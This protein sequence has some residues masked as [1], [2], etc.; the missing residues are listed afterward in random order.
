EACAGYVTEKLAAALA[1]R[2]YA[3]LAI[4]GGSSPK[5][6]FARLA[7][8]ELPWDR[9]H[10]FWVDE[11]AVPPDDSESNYRLAH[12]TLLSKVA[13]PATNVHRI[14]AELVPEEAAREYE[15]EIRGFFRLGHGQMPAFDVMHRGMGPD[16]HTASLFPGE[17]LIED[18][19]GL[20]AA[21]YAEK[22]Q[23]W[24]ITL[25]PGP[26]LAARETVMLVAGGDKAEP[27]RAVL[28]GPIDPVH[29]P[30]QLMPQGAPS[31]AWFL[32]EAAARLLTK[33]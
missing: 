16:A 5:P 8:A 20:V 7:S 10:V 17:A 26:L 3:T 28:E 11:R 32:D 22:K 23:Q 2:G 33:E 1:V 30:A 14:R 24:R 27:L 12:E 4:S 13:I 18:R 19:A 31:V 21:V 15:R 6:M 9:V 25:L 29:F